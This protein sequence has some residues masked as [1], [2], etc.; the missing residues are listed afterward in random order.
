[1]YDLKTQYRQGIKLCVRRGKFKTR[2]GSS[3][4]IIKVA[5]KA[6]L[7]RGNK[8]VSVYQLSKTMSS[9]EERKT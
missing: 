5:L 2:K 6:M 8:V 1:M 4:A 9:K 7:G 3:Y